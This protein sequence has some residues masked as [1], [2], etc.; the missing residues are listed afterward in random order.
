MLLLSL[1]RVIIS[2]SLFIILLFLELNNFNPLI[3]RELTRER[4]IVDSVASLFPQLETKVS[5]ALW[6]RYLILLLILSSIYLG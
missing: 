5:E 6:V 3:I 2:L 4:F 1:E